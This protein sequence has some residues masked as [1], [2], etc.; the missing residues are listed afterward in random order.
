MN[1]YNFLVGENPTNNR[2]IAAHLSAMQTENSQKAND[3]SIIGDNSFDTVNINGFSWSFKQKYAEMINEE[4]V[5][6][7]IDGYTCTR[8][9]GSQTCIVWVEKC[10]LGYYAYSN[11][12]IRKGNGE[13]QRDQVGLSC[14]IG[15]KLSNVLQRENAIVSNWGNG[16]VPLYWCKEPITENCNVPS[17]RGKFN[18]GNFDKM[19]MRHINGKRCVEIDNLLYFEED[20]KY[21][22]AEKDILYLL[23]GIYFTNAGYKHL[24]VENLKGVLCEEWCYD[25]GNVT[26]TSDKEEVGYVFKTGV[27][28]NTIRKGMLYWKKGQYKNKLIY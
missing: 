17:H 3:C 9:F 28:Q 12:F 4:N 7:I 22:H 14:E 10:E 18:N 25:Y 2:K 21:L 11:Y 16:C 15:E 26:L 27:T 13:Y 6:K 8:G 5:G 23:D 1:L 24:N 19:W 20:L